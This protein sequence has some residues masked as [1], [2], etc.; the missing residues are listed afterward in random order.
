MMNE[1]GWNDPPLF[2]YQSNPPSNTKSSNK[3]ALLNKRPAYPATEHHH[4]TSTTLSRDQPPPTG[5][6]GVPVRESSSQ[7]EATPTSEEAV[8][9]LSQSEILSSLNE[10]VDDYKECIEE[11]L[12]KEIKKRLDML[13]KQWSTL[14]QPVHKRLSSLVQ[15]LQDKDYKKAEDI[16]VGLMVDHVSEVKQ[17]L[18]GIKKLVDIVKDRDKS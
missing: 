18:I 6:A 8:R 4:V 11:R 9:C 17:W 2:S 3:P 1:Y 16:H 5:T 14:S 10:L 7:V 15:A 13:D 12:L